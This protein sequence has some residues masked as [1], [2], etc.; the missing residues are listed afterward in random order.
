M[1]VVVTGG[2]N[3]KDYAKIWE[4]LDKWHK[5][6]GITCIRHGDA[7]GVDRICKAWAVSR[8]I[9]EES[10]PAYWDNLDAP[11]A[12]IR[13]NAK[14][15]YNAN[16]GHFRNQLMLDCN[17]KPDYAIVFRGGAGTMDMFRRIKRSGITYILAEC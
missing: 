2:R 10:F 3:N 13:Y 11:G 8:G 1:R 14:G 4:T 16:A 9:A 12:K 7:Q 6:I 5:T 17:P 15:P